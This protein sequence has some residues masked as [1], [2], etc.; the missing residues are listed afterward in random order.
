MKKSLLFQ[1]FLLS[2]LCVSAQKTPPKPW[3]PA[4]ADTTYPRTIIHSS[5]IQQVKDSLKAGRNIAIYHSVYDNALS[6]SPIGNTTINDKSSRSE[7]AKNAAFVF[8]LGVKPVGNSTDSL[9]VSERVLIRNKVL[10]L[11]NEINTYVNQFTVD[12]PF[13]FDFWQYTSRDIIKYAEAYDFLKGGGVPDD[14]LLNARK[15]L[16]S[17]TGNLYEQSARAVTGFSFFQTYKNNSALMSASALGL[18]AV[19]LNN[20]KDSAEQFH[21]LNWIN[22]AMWNVH[23]ILWWDI[24]RQS[25]VKKY[26]GYGEGPYYGRVALCNVMPFIKAMGNFIPDT[27]VYYIYNQIDR[28]LRNPWYDTNYTKIFDWYA[29][30]RMPDGRMPNIEDSY[31]HK[32]FPELAVMR[33]QKYVWP[34]YYSGLDS[35][36]ENSFNKQITSIYDMRADYIAANLTEQ[37]LIDSNFVAMP[38]AGTAIFRSGSDSDATYLSLLGK[39]GNNLIVTDAHNQADDASFSMMIKG[40]TMALDP[41]LFFYL[42]RDSV[43]RAANHNMILVDGK[44]TEPGFPQLPNGANAYIEKYFKSGVQ[45]YAEVRTHYQLADIN[46]KVMHV[47]NKYFLLIDHMNSDTAHEYSMLIHGYGRFF[48]DTTFLGAFNDMTANK[49]AAWLRR[50]SGLFTYTESDQAFSLT[51]K[52][53]P[54]EHTLGLLQYHNVITATSTVT[55]N[56]SYMTCLQPFTTLATDTLPLTTLNI[57]GAVGFKIV[58]GANTDL[59]VNK[60]F[61]NT[62]T[63]DKTATGLT[64]SFTSDGKFVWISENGGAVKDLF[65]H[66]A[67]FMLKDND[68]LWSALSPTNMQFVATNAKSFKG[69]TGDTGYIRFHVGEYPYQVFGE[70]IKSFNYNTTSK[71]ITI[72]FGKAASFLINVDDARTGLTERQEPLKLNIYPNP[73]NEM[74]HFALED[75]TNSQCRLEIFDLSG[76][77][78]LTHALA[79]NTREFDVLTHQLDNG[80][81]FAVLKDD[82]ANR[83]MSVKLMIS[84]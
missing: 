72:Y 51:T 15:G 38:D 19:V 8:L 37:P 14:L 21:P 50:K 20:H 12:S 68:T 58:D 28:K 52:L 7:I 55:Q 33:K 43:S 82:T 59:A 80:L 6:L 67:T 56:M 24:R 44:A 64:N 63:I 27:A 46:R 11:L 70:G 4:R 34:N 61:S 75:F 9:T 57:S 78:V 77:L 79:A 31:N 39:N 40:Q 10:G 42:L 35:L 2:V 22:C 45:N 36:Q 62:I 41:G 26:A 16:K 18:A 73:A 13:N 66:K 29:G 71:V 74:V 49:R 17:L 5:E 47:R 48:G 84:R 32:F 69:F 81:Y 76:K 83:S 53:A 1:I 60:T 30:I 3:L 25:D 54:H 65:A 23:N